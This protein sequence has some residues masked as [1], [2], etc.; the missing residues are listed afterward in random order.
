LKTTTR[1]VVVLATLAEAA[2]DVSWADLTKTDT[3]GEVSFAGMS[4]PTNLAFKLVLNV[5]RASF[6]LR[7]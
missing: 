6:R 2:G 1:K 3:A 5:N 4:T 7:Q